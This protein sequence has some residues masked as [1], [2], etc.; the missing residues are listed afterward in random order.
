MLGWHVWF[1][2]NGPEYQFFLWPEHQGKARVRASGS[3]QNTAKSV[4]SKKPKSGSFQA[5]IGKPGTQNL[6]LARSEKE[7]LF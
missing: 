2:G 6:D 5:G 3:P 1:Q 4:A 7:A